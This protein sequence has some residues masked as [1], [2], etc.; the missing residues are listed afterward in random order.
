MPAFHPQQ[1]SRTR[2]IADIVEP[3]I[4]TLP[5]DRVRRYA[6]SRLSLPHLLHLLAG[7]GT[8][9]IPRVKS[10]VPQLGQRN[11]SSASAPWLSQKAPPM[12]KPALPKI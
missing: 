4:T 10:D 5:E 1:T 7:H 9:Q 11:D 8:L 3:P 2:P 12:R 6:V